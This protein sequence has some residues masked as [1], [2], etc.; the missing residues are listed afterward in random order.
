MRRIFNILCLFA[1][2]GFCK[3]LKPEYEA[4]SEVLGVYDP[5]ILLAKVDAIGQKKL[6]QRFDITGFPTMLWFR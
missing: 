1:Y 4:A 5:P 3:K 6:A 2:S